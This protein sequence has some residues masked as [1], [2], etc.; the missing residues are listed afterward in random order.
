ME[1]LKFKDL[2][3]LYFELSKKYTTE[4]ILDMPVYLG[5]DD[6][7]NGFHCG[8]ECVMLDTINKAD[9]TIISEINETPG[10]FQ[11]TDKAI[12]IS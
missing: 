6:E 8:W 3:N 2:M 7:L 12:L 10:N 11:I 5:D 4:E 1:Q 9:M